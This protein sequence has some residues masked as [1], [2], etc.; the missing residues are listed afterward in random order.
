VV[1]GRYI[2]VLKGGGTRSA[3][4]RAR[5]VDQNVAQA[6]RGA[7]AWTPGSARRRGVRRIHV[8]A[9]AR[10]GAPGPGRRL[11]GTEQIMSIGAVDWGLD[12]IDQPKLPLD[13]NY[14]TSLT[15]KGVTAYVI[16]TGVRT[17]HQDSADASAP[18]SPRAGRPRHGGLQRPRHPRR[19]HHRRLRAR[20]AKAATIVP[21]RVLGC[22]GSGS[23]SAI[24]KGV[25]WVTANAKGASVAN[26]SLGGGVSR[27]LDAA[28][29]RSVAAGVT[30]AVA[31]GNSNRDACSTSPARVP[32]P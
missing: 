30:Y 26:M 31:A 19:R 12:R 22:A 29:A 16:D 9:A 10:P 21:V 5:Y 6:R 24:I 13:G 32:S 27:A 2:V 15:G 23:T 4:A 17:T 28:V 25:D 3:T 18:G 11:R 1:A 7:C 20:V 8:R 14:R